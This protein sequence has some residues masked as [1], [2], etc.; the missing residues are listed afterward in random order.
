MSNVLLW[1]IAVE[2]L[3]VLCVGGYFLYQILETLDRF[4][5]PAY[6]EPSV[7][8]ETLDILTPEVLE[9]EALRTDDDD[10]TGTFTGAAWK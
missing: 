1:M 2:L 6:S 7:L 8:P 9:A 5:D 3:V 10:T 4:A